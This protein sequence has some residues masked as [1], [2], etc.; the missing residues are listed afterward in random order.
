MR[1]KLSINSSVAKLTSSNPWFVIFVFVEPPLQQRC[2][3]FSASLLCDLS[4][5]PSFLLCLSLLCVIAGHVILSLLRTV[6][7]SP[8]YIT[9]QIMAIESNTSCC[10]FLFLMCVSDYSEL[11]LQC[12]KHK[13][14]YLQETLQKPCAQG[15]TLLIKMEQ[16]LDVSIRTNNSCRSPFSF[17]NLIV[18]STSVCLCS[19]KVQGHY[20][21][22]MSKH[23]W[24]GRQCV[25]VSHVIFQ[26]TSYLLPC[27]Y[28]SLAFTLQPIFT[29][30]STVA[31][32]LLS[33]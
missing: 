28:L 18:L 5:F 8:S 3:S 1:H 19:F 23:L 25:V 33:A 17:G 9:I 14:D 7:A 21:P 32:V 6:V 2:P 16:V 27:L 20:F 10:L 22:K 29:F 24:K 12:K 15:Q 4:I 31:V 11:L 13:R 30:C 26:Y